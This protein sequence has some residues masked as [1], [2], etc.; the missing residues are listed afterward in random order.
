MSEEVKQVPP[1]IKKIL[2]DINTKKGIEVPPSNEPPVPPATP[3]ATPPDNPNPDKP[4][5][6][7]PESK[8]KSDDILEEIKKI[9]GLEGINSLDDLKKLVNKEEKKPISDEGKKAEIKKW[10]I[11]QKKI[12]PEIFDEFEKY[13]KLSNID[14]AFNVYKSERNGDINPLTDEEYTEEELRLEFED[15]HYLYLEDT[16]P[17]KKRALKKIDLIADSN[18]SFKEISHL[19]SEYES[20]L[21]QNQFE[22]NINSQIPKIVEDGI[23]YSIKDEK[24]EEIKVK[25]P[26]NKKALASLK[27][28]FENSEAVK[29]LDGIKASLTQA[30]LLSNL[31]KV[32]HEIATAYHGQKIIEIEAAKK[33]IDIRKSEF[34]TKVGDVPEAIQRALDRANKNRASKN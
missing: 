4:D 17:K 29:D 8:G 6:P 23:S 13:S 31:D 20:N 2:D 15:E 18:N 14:K 12:K 26:V 3:P 33:G 25:I 19:D 24:G 22:Q 9:E 11:E 5:N 7:A 30:Y 32:I 27:I 10:A 28:G 21:L 34:E 1:E 16:D